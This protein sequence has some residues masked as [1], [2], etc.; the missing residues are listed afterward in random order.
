MYMYD[1]NLHITLECNFL[2]WN[3]PDS[4]NTVTVALGYIDTLAIRPNSSSAT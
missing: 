3:T 2:L 4:D 1:V